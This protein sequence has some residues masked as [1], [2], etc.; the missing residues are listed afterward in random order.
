MKNIR[1][2]NILDDF[3]LILAS[4][5]EIQ[6]MISIHRFKKKPQWAYYKADGDKRRKMRS[7]QGIYIQFCDNP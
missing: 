5:L 1:L 6:F 3:A 2:N 4:D 7:R